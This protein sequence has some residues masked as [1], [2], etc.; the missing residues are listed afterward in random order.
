MP[1]VGADGDVGRR[2]HAR[3]QREEI[4]EQAATGDGEVDAGEEEGASHRERRCPSTC[5]LDLLAAMA[6]DERRPHRL[7]GH[8]R[9]RRRDR[10]EREARDPRSRSGRRGTPR[11]GETGDSAAD[12]L[13]TPPAR[14]AGR[15]ARARM[16]RLS[17]LRQNAMA[18]VARRRRSMSGAEVDTAPRPPPGCPSRRRAPTGSRSGDA[19]TCRVAR[20]DDRPGGT[21]MPTSRATDEM[22]EGARLA[23]PPHRAA[24]RPGVL[25]ARV[26]RRAT[27]PSASA[28]S[29]AP[30]RRRRRCPTGR[31]TS[32]AGAR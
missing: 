15:P 22:R 2:Q 8:E 20:L 30:C 26:P 6:S 14:R 7:G 13:A 25:L 23:R 12:E 19:T 3:R 4:T 5:R 1:D 16:G 31:P 29:P 21:T 10:R 17:A 11:R 28:A 27:R 24:R 32:A 18:R 9:Y